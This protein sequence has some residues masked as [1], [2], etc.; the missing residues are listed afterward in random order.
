MNP[1]IIGNATL[2]NCDCLEVLPMLTEV[3]AVIT[4]P[5][6]KLTSGGNNSKQLKHGI[7]DK[8]VYNNSGCLFNVVEFSDWIP[9]VGEIKSDSFDFYAMVNDKNVRDCLNVAHKS[10]FKLH[11]ILVWDRVNQTPNRWFMKR[12]EFILY[13][14]KGRARNINNMGESALFQM[15][16]KMGNR[17]HPTEKPVEVMDI[18]I[19]NSTHKDQIVVDPFM[20]SGSTGVSCIHTHRKFVGVEIDK[21]YFD[22]ACKR[23]EDAQ[24]Q[25]R[26]FDG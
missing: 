25:Q 4:D 9:L 19:N 26:M 3:D 12:C 10:G 14:W 16:C 8:D 18:M 24:R 15:K 23:I 7:F 1:V 5:P 20:G 2:Y 11:N 22:I 17:F 21:K 13:F 6:Y